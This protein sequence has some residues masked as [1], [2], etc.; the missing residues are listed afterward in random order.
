MS[1]GKM[2]TVLFFCAKRCG[3]VKEKNF[4]VVNVDSVINLEKPKLR[5]FI[6]KMRENLA[7]A[8]EIEIECVSVKAKTGEKVDAVGRSE[9]IKAEAVFCL[10]KKFRQIKNRSGFHPSGFV[11][12]LSIQLNKHSRRSF[13]RVC[14]T[15]CQVLLISRLCESVD[16]IEF[17]I[18]PIISIRRIFHFIEKF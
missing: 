17:I 7:R 10:M 15:A 9:A 14:R 16:F 11:K 8:L 6:E 4:R 3:L 5:P 13:C 12:T 18:A 2:P 1:D